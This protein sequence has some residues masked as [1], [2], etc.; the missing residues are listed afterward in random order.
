MALGIKESHLRNGFIIFILLSVAVMVGILI[1]TTEPET[2]QQIRKFRIGFIPLL[3]FLSVIRW[4]M[5][6]MFFVILAKHGH[7][8]S[9]S[10]NRATV[11]RLEGTVLS[12]VVPI[13]VGTFA[14][15]S[16]LLHK[17]KFKISES[18][19]MTVLRGIMPV[20]LFLLNI[21]ILLCMRDKQESSK[22]FTDL[23]NLVSLPIVISLF[24]FAVALFY[25]DRMKR[26][27]LILIHWFG[28]IKKFR[29][30]EKKMLAIERRVF[31]E[32]DH[33]SGIFWMY[34]RERKGVLIHATFWIFMSFF[35]DYVVAMA[36]MWGFGY[37][38]PF[39]HA[40]A[41]QF[42]IRPIIYFAPTPG[43]AGIWEFSYL[44]FFSLYMP[45]SLIG[46][47]VL[48]WRLLLSYIPIIIGGFYTT[49]EFAQ[50][51]KFRE[52]VQK[53]AKHSTKATET[54]SE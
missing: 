1:W 42:L 33:F 9:I 27:A 4:Y 30:S 48:I 2:W 44:G 53:E 10:L 16:Y 18:M 7:K 46:I 6:G 45:H 52:I 25:P 31:R 37:H 36:I 40:I 13:I 41:V 47:S 20:F 35:V 11:I 8:S 3:I 28:R 23:I 24:F 49:R 32:I 14:M 22:F 50:D 54:G 34:L 19:A 21:P 38:P 15:H 17:E 5:D 26:A 12:A 43:G 51:E 29:R 39:W